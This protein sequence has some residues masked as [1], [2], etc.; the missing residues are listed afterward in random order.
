MLFRSTAFARKIS[1]LRTSKIGASTA[2]EH[3]LRT[4]TLGMV[5][6][7]HFNPGRQRY[8]T[9][10]GRHATAWM[11]TAA[12]GQ[13]RHIR[14]R[15]DDGIQLLLVEVGSRNGFEQRQRIRVSGARQHV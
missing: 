6:R 2:I 10:V 3:F 7:R 1:S 5:A 15:S 13:G 8:A 4:E 14:R 12:G 9:L 11:K